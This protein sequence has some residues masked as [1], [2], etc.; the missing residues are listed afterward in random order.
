M[1]RRCKSEIQMLRRQITET[2]PKAEAYDMLQTVLGLLPQKT[3][4]GCEDILW[5][6]DKEVQKIEQE[7]AQEKERKTHTVGSTI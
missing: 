4:G 2:A 5:I 7:I 3:Q 1:L 6:I